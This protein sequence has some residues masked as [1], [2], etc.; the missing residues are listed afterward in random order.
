MSRIITDLAVFDVGS[1]GLTL[2]EI[3]DGITIEELQKKTE[4]PFMVS[5]NLR[6][7]QA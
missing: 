1:E 4:A 3:L 7:Y 2:I 5:P 6:P